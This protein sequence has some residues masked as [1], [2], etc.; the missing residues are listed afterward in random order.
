M[1][2]KYYTPC[3]EC[4]AFNKELLRFSP[5]ASH[6]FFAYDL[7]RAFAP[8]SIVELGSHYGS[9]FFAFAQ[10]AKDAHLNTKLYAVDTWKGDDYTSHYGEEVFNSF[11]NVWKKYYSQIDIKLLRSTFDEA[12]SGFPDESI[13]LL[14]IDGSHHYEDIKHDFVSWL[15]KVRKS[16]II[17]LHDISEDKVLGEIMG[18][19]KFWEEIKEQYSYTSEFLFSWGLGVLFLAKETYDLIFSYIDHDHYQRL[20]N[21]LDVEGRDLIRQNFFKLNDNK[22]YINFLRKQA[23]IK[24]DELKK[25][26]NTINGKDSYIKELED[27]CSNVQKDYEKT[28]K[29]KDAYITQL[30][31]NG[32]SIKRDYEDTIAGKDQYIKELE[33]NQESFRKTHLDAIE[34]K[35]KCFSELEATIS[36]IKTDY[37]FTIAQKD[38]YIKQLTDNIANVQNDYQKTIDGKN[39]YIAELEA[40]INSIKTNYELTIDQK[41]QYIKQL[42]DNIANIQNDYQKTI[43]GKDKYIAE[44]EDKSFAAASEH[45]TAMAEKESLIKAME[46]EQ[47]RM[48]GQYEDELAE[49]TQELNEC[50]E[51]N[52][53]LV[54]SFDRL[55]TQYQK[56]L[57]YKIS[58]LIM[59]K[60]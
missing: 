35:D 5:W 25:Y 3:F 58:H 27:R 54:L 55:N 2:W 33:E 39:N 60:E 41:K 19:H 45:K 17:L 57:E 11:T 18:S 44:L 36:S 47:K 24:D 38:Q 16:G 26:Q 32:K 9:S 20:S 22:K 29:D 53:Q 48:I 13:D 7:I 4:D 49:I 34:E 59:K 6:R 28:L 51:K 56:T 50:R 15:P 40:T 1:D 10:A 37:E 42:T 46:S 52:Q 8:Q 14:H 21:N 23:D 12:R 31:E 43:D 30:E